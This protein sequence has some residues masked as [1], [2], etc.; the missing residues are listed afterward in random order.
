VGA[1]AKKAKPAGGVKRDAKGAAK[2]AGGAKP[3]RDAS[4]AAG[5]TSAEVDAVDG[6]GG[7]G[8]PAAAPDS[9]APDPAAAPGSEQP[10]ERAEP[11]E[12]AAG[13]PYEPA[14][15]IDQVELADQAALETETEP[16][17][18]AP[19]EPA[20]QPAAEPAVVSR[21]RVSA[22]KLVVALLLG[23]LGF[24]FAVQVRSVADDPTA[25]A[26][27]E[28]DLV[29]ILA[30]LDT[31]EERLREEIRELEDTR[32][33]LSTAG[34]SQQEAL[35]EATRRADELGILAGTLPAQGPGV[36]VQL[37]GAPG[38]ITAAT[39][40]DAVQELRSAG[41]EAM[42]IEGTTGGAVRVIAS[43]YFVDHEDGI[44]VDGTPL[45]GAYRIV[46]IGDPQTLAPALHIPGGVVASVQGD[47]GTVTVQEEPG[48]VEVSTVRQ[49]D[50]LEHARPDS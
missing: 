10:P 14:D 34:Q 40:L 19:P 38:V 1:V 48:G 50:T 2:L 44:V 9:D 30:N 11:P 46:A 43:T 28:E 31:H 23:L 24:S 29:R 37:S 36:V 12:P 49:P 42:Q 17:P 45:T 35:A 22:T 26:L 39:M 6:A 4:G 41:A 32:T 18:P 16:A 47:G 15:Q 8:Q 27:D 3:D 13:E 33:R 7:P 21:S 25:A 5:A 20:E